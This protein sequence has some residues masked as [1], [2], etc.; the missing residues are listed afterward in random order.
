V[1]DKD[2]YHSQ[3]LN[4]DQPITAFANFGF[5]VYQLPFYEIPESQKDPLFGRHMQQQQLSRLD[6]VQM[7]LPTNN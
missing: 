2:K 6:C 4:L 7:I 5:P 1:C 3:N